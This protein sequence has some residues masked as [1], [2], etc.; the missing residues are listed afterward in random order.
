M[1]RPP[2][3]ERVARVAIY[4]ALI[5]ATFVTLIPFV[6]LV[7][8]SLK[9]REDV[10]SG[11]LLPIGDGWLGIA[12][13][14]L[15]MANFTRL[16]ELGLGR[17]ILNSVFLASVT[18]VLA[19]LCC[20]MGGYALAKFRFRG[21]EFVTGSVLAMLVIPGVLLLAPTYQL[22]YLLGLL[23]SHG[24]L[25]LPAIGPAFGVFLFRQSMLSSVPNELLESARM[26]GCGELR[27]F[28]AIVLPLVRPMI[29]AFLMITFLG[30]WNNFIGP[31]VVL[32]SPEKMPLAVAIAQLKG[33]YNQ[34]LGMLMAGTL[35]SVLP[36]MVLFLMLQKDFI[37]GL[38]TGAVKG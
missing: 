27:I 13:D 32:Q 6:F 22:L 7:C 10:A 23:D 34:E 16:Y 38:T 33:V 20:A 9:M 36:V 5:G 2:V 3:A 12:W 18:S 29:G 19:T 28:F 15:T 30:M 14:R 31:Q 11:L 4:L 24:G 8:G 35:V 25:I 37:S 26:D 17:S 1:S 21:R